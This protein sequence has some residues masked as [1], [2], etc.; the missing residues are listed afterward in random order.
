MIFSMC[1]YKMK[2]KI[3]L[4]PS[5]MGEQSAERLFPA[6]NVQIVQN[7][8][9]FVVENARTARRFVKKICPEKNIEESCFF[10]I[11]K[12]DPADKVAEMI[13]PVLEGE[14]LGIISEA[15]MPC[16][17]DPGNLVVAEA[18][19]HNIKVQPLVGP[20]SIIMA[21]ISSGFNGQNFAFHGYVPL[22]DEKR[23]TIQQ[24]E[25]IA[26]KSGQTQI[27]METPYRNMQLFQDLLTILKPST[28]LC[29]ATDITLETEEIVTKSVQ[30]W[31]KATPNLNKR[32]SIFL[33]M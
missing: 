6:Y 2:G 28:K 3:Y 24:W 1:E 20:N 31:K 11:N 18:H 7:I 9:F 27:F 17:A 4:I 10:E 25:S 30:D 13:K 22:K 29:I 19:K 32:P 21:L 26:L 5:E 15:G 23:R 14:N 8:A 16:I 12:Y 33:I